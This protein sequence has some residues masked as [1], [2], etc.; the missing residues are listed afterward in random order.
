LVRPVRLLVVLVGVAAASGCGGSDGN[1]SD[2]RRDANRQ[3][4]CDA[5]Q[6]AKDVGDT[7][8]LRDKPD[9]CKLH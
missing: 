6:Y 7:E 1:T 2:D 8:A 4:L 9:Y 3:A 5:Y